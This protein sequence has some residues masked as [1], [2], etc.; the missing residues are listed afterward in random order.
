MKVKELKQSLTSG[1]MHGVFTVPIMMCDDPIG[2]YNKVSAARSRPL[3]LF[4]SVGE[5][6]LKLVK[7]MS[8]YLT[9]AGVKYIVENLL[10]SSAKIK[11]SLLDKLREKLIKKTIGWPIKHQTGPVFFKLIMNFIKESTPK[12]MRNIITQLQTLG[13]KDYDGEFKQPQRLKGRTK[14]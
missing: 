11:A 9:L 13:V 2:T 8:E 4:T 5:T 7:N 6:D 3:E 12:S 14:F 10:W 1:D